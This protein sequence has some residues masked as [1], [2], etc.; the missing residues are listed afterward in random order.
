MPCAALDL[1]GAE[2][3]ASAAFLFWTLEVD[4]AFVAVLVLHYRTIVESAVGMNGKWAET[5]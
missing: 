1:R 3:P 4:C 5:K 2:A